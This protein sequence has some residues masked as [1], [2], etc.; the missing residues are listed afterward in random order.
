V[1]TRAAND[2]GQSLSG[3]DTDDEPY[4]EFEPADSLEQGWIGDGVPIGASK[5]LADAFYNRLDREVGMGDI[6][7]TI[8]LNDTRMDEERDLVDSAY[9]DRENLPFDV[10]IHRDLTVD[11]LQA[12]LETESDF[13][14]YIGH[15]DPDGFECPDGKLDV[16]TLDHTGIDAFVLNACSSYHQGIKLIEAGAI[17]GIVTLTDIINSE[18]VQ[19]GE[20][21]ASL[22]N[23]GFPLRSALSIAREDS[24]LG[25]Q[26]IAVGDS[27]MT[28][29]QPSSR[30]PNFLEI[31]STS[32][33]YSLTIQTYSTDTAGLGTVYTPFIE[34]VRSYFLTPGCIG[35]F[36]VSF[37]QAM[38][39]LE[40]EDVPVRLPSGDIM[41]SSLL[42]ETDLPTEG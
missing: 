6:S 1:L 3:E 25:G 28:V 37:D 21:I 36:D 33:G 5:L 29:T 18:A 23:A 16:G 14:H 35:S 7:I 31:S 17:G 34:G 8:V 20:L 32:S 4:I 2:R 39:F 27:G 11:E 13:L 10:S 12:T 15:T 19:I 42:E 9:G 22:L 40:M 41:W 26:Y 38:K 30:V 24:I